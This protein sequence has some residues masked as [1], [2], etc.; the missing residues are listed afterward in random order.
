MAPVPKKSKSKKTKQSPKPKFRKKEDRLESNG[1]RKIVL[2]IPALCSECGE[3]FDNKVHMEKHKKDCSP[4]II[5]CSN[6]DKVFKTEAQVN[7]I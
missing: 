3:R 6:C 1:D 4:K 5:K 2:K 7:E